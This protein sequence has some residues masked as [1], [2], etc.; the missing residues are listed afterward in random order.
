[1]CD[2]MMTRKK[3]LIATKYKQVEML[4]MPLESQGSFH[5]S[6]KDESANSQKIASCKL[7]NKMRF[8]KSIF[9]CN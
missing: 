1:M 2:K 9:L 5:V 3:Q 6:I 4:L 7:L 8:F